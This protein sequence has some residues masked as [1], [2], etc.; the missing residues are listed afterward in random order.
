MTISNLY[1][2]N[3][4]V[5]HN[6]IHK[7][8]LPPIVCTTRQLRYG[9]CWR[10]RITQC[11]AFKIL[12]T[13]SVCQTNKFHKTVTI[14]VKISLTDTV[15]KAETESENLN[16]IFFQPVNG[17]MKEKEGTEL[18]SWRYW[19]CKHGTSA[20]KCLLDREFPLPIT[21][22]DGGKPLRIRKGEIV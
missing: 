10:I 12:A 5:L 2:K 16:D 6:A 4:V 21:H 9:I 19:T 22:L 18:R 20:H 1:K 14:N 11:E 3:Q 7:K 8:P 15:I 17:Y 13:N